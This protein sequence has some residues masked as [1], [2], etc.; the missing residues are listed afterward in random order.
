M[1]SEKLLY[2]FLSALLDSVLR[3]FPLA[4]ME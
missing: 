2:I 1:E 4:G 3:E